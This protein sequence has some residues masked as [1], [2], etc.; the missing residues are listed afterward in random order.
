MKATPTN[1]SACATY[2]VFGTHL[3]QAV[4]AK[5]QAVNYH[6]STAASSGYG[7]WMLSTTDANGQT[8]N[9]TYDVLGRLTSVI[10]PGDTLS[11]P[12]TRYAYSNTCAA[13]T[14]SPCLELDTTTRVTSGSAT[15]TTT[16]QWFDGMGRLVQTQSPGPNQF[17]K[18][19]AIGSLLVTY[20]L[21]DNMGRATTTSLPYA[22]A[23]SATTGYAT[24]DLTQ[25]RT[26]TTYDSLGRPTSSVSY[27]LGSV[28]LSEATTS[29]IVGQGVASFAVGTTTAFEQTI[30]LDAY[31]HQSIQYTDGIGQDRYEQVFSGTGSPY[32]V[33]RTVQ[34]NRDEVGNVT[35]VVT[36]DNTSYGLVRTNAMYDG[37]KRRIGFNDWDQG[38]CNHGPLP[39][40][41]S[42]T[43]D[44]AWKVSYDPNGNVLSQTDPRNQTTY[45]SYDALDRPLCRGTAASQVNPCQS[46]AYATYFYDSYDNRSNP[47]VAFPSGCMAPGGTSAPVGV[48]VAETFSNAAGSGWRCNGYDARGQTIAGALSVTADGQ[49][50]TQ[51]VSMT[52]NDLGAI[53]SLTYP[54]GETVTSNYDSNGRLRLAYLGTTASSD[55]VAFLVGRVSYINSGQLAGLAIGGTANKTSVPTPLFG[56][57][58]GYDGMQ[59]LITS[60]ATRTGASSPFWSQQQY[61]LQLST[62][63]PTTSGSSLTDNQSFCYDALDQVM[64]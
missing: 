11:Q 41:C 30:T 3:L 40:S 42:N 49:T 48:K 56:T 29:Y 44:S 6:Y 26:V 12:T 22:I 59:R 43:S 4:N 10:E 37:L 38:D 62:T 18:V 13:G 14:T 39:A 61:I 57:T 35:S 36:Y 53:N 34:Y 51:N 63:L 33:V 28:I 27:G 19:P 21:Y 45:T 16:R 25:A 15:T 7:Q 55:P 20:T 54:D 2:D 9:Y 31:H 52:Y 60:S 17:S 47:G 50:T 8:T 46:S 32:T 24:P 23:T 1:A 58:L 5:N 64:W